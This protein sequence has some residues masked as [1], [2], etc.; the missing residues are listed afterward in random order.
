ML[1]SSCR[2]PGKLYLYEFASHASN[3]KT[4]PDG[5]LASHESNHKTAPDGCGDTPRNDE[6]PREKPWLCRRTAVTTSSKE[7]LSRHP[8]SS[9]Y[10]SLL[11]FV[12]VSKPFVLRAAM[13]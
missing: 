7:A 6:V 8:S 13:S 12:G 1:N 10:L 5:E 9:L 4:T 3:H 2:V 11:K